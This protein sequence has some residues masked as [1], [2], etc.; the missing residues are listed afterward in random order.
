M[1]R[2][3]A[4]AAAAAAALAAAG[5]AYSSH[6]GEAP[7]RSDAVWG[8]GHFVNPAGVPRDLS[9]LG[10][11]GGRRGADGS[12][13]FGT[14]GVVT[15]NRTEVTCLAVNGNKAVVGGII[16]E[17]NTG[18]FV[19][20]ANVMYYIDNGGPGSSARDRSWVTIPLGRELPHGSSGVP[21]PSAGSVGGI[22]F[23]LHRTGFG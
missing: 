17:T 4:I 14:N 22:C 6:T 8:G 11:R 21:D 23:T 10:V 18:A 12:L 13:I 2:R 16:R 7:A 19:G 15:I 5:A 20:S 1:S 9:V 3:T